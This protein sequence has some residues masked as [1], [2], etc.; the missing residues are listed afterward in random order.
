MGQ[1][2]RRLH[3][4]RIDWSV[5]RGDR[6][7]ASN[8]DRRTGPAPRCEL[9]H[10]LFAARV[11]VSL[12]PNRAWCAGAEDGRADETPRVHGIARQRGGM[13]CDRAGAAA[14]DAGDR[15]P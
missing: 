3:V 1:R 10:T 6:A 15:I 7:R 8:A 4:T 2:S 9:F 5:I 14:C 13:A 11:L 12:I